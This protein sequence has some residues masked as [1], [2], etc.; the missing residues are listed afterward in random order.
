MSPGPRDGA[1]GTTLGSVGPVHRARTIALAAAL[2]LLLMVGSS[3]ARGDA[4]P[5]APIAG[6][7]VDG[8]AGRITPLAGG[9]GPALTAVQPARAQVLARPEV[10]HPPSALATAL[11]VLGVVVAAALDRRRHGLRRL[12]EMT[13]RSRTQWWRPTPGGR[14]PP[15]P[16]ALLPL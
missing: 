12:L 10:Q 1:G 3:P 16:L 15:R 6:A 9:P 11:L 2:A 4:L 7:S 5:G 13:I 8:G 14:A